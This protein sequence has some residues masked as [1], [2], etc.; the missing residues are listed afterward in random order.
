M[1]KPVD[2]PRWH[3]PYFSKNPSGHVTPSQAPPSSSSVSMPPPAAIPN[4]PNFEDYLLQPADDG[5]LRRAW[6]FLDRL[7]DSHVKEFYQTD[8][9]ISSVEK[10]AKDIDEYEIVTGSERIRDLSTLMYWPQ[11]RQLGLRI[12]AA[13]ILLSSIDFHGLWEDT[14]LPVQV[15]K[16]FR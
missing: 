6:V 3:F 5:T 10:I 16:L 15:V 8:Q 4:I 14:S 12:C 11:Y 13:R 7:I 9:T 2:K 1:S